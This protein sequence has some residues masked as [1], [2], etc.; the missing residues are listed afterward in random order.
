M[1]DI[2]RFCVRGNN[3]Q[4]NPEPQP[5]ACS[6]LRIGILRAEHVVVPRPPVIHMTMTA[7]LFQYELCPSAL[8]IEAT[9][10][11]LYC[12]IAARVIGVIS[13]G[14]DPRHVRQLFVR[15]VGKNFPSGD[16]M[17]FQSGPL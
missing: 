11:A 14:H 8:T 3:D 16:L 10:E 5:L 17:F 1:R 7:V 13:G 12:R 4:W 2:S 15:N 6:G 9:H